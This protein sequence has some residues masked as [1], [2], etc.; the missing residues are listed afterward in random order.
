MLSFT[1]KS[2]GFGN[3]CY[4]LSMVNIAVF[5]SV[6][7]AHA[8]QVPGIVLSPTYEKFGFCMAGDS[9]NVFVQSHAVCFYEDTIFA[10][11]LVLLT[12]FVGKGC[13]SKDQT[14]FHITNAVS[15]FVH[16]LA[17]L[18]LAYR[19]YLE[20]TVYYFLK[21]FELTQYCLKV[22]QL[23]PNLMWKNHRFSTLFSQCFG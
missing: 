14:T 19:D 7:I 6:I 9:K 10:I 12:K 13:M 4:V 23:K 20:G 11:L 22:L 2:H 18:M 21:L 1:S 15:I 8:N 3:V 5:I 17:H 16:G